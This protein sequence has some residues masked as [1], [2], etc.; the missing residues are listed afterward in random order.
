MRAWFR[1]MELLALQDGVTP[2][3]LTASKRAIA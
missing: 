3:I 2:A 1:R